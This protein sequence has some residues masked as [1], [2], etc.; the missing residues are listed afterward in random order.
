MSELIEVKLDVTCSYM[1]HSVNIFIPLRD[2]GHAATRKHGVVIND[3]IDRN[4]KKI[5]ISI[6]IYMKRK[7]S[8]KRLLLRHIFLVDNI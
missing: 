1:G 3:K 5:Y 7:H 2:M 8:C 4:K 6:I